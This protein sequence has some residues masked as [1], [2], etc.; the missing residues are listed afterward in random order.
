MKFTT[1]GFP[2][3][4]PEVNFIFLLYTKANVSLN[5]PLLIRQYLILK[6]LSCVI[7][8]KLSGRVDFTGGTGIS[9]TVAS[10]K[11]VTQIDFGKL[12]RKLYI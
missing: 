12:S 6:I 5:A 4:F 3:F 2:I 7:N 10:A 8:I 9:T 1:R 11:K